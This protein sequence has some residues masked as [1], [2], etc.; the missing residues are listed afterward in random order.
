[1][2]R[3]GKKIKKYFQNVYTILNYFIDIKFNLVFIFDRHRHIYRNS[4]YIFIYNTDSTLKVP[5]VYNQL[6]ENLS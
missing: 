6:F 3:V 2:M 5:T 4:K 1:M